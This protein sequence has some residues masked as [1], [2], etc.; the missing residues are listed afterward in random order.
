[1]HIVKR[2]MYIKYQILYLNHIEC[3]ANLTGP[4]GDLASPGWPRNY[5]HHE[6][7]TWNI[8][9]PENKVGCWD[10]DF[11]GFEFRMCANI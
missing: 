3:G 10:W 2:N 8:T 9:V 5:S 11:P 7:C 1:M 6:E 4:S